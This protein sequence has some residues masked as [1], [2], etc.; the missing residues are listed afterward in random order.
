M[1]E[2]KKPVVHEVE[3]PPIEPMDPMHQIL[4]GM[5]QMQQKTNETLEK[6]TEKLDALSEEKVINVEVPK[7]QDDMVKEMNNKKIIQRKMYKV[8]TIKQVIPISPQDQQLY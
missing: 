4:Q 3:A 6:I 7:T 2:E 1:T 5:L 8:M